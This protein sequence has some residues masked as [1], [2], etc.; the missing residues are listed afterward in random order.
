MAFL[1]ADSEYVY[2]KLILKSSISVNSTFDIA[3]N[4][5]INQVT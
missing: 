4:S 1:I 5:I 3:I 2:S